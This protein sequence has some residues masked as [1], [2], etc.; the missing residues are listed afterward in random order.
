MGSIEDVDQAGWDKVI[1]T[2]LSGVY[3]VTKA[4][5]DSL[6]EKG[7]NVVMT[8]SVSGIGGD[9]SMF[10][11]NAAKGGVTNLTRALALDAKNSGV[12]VNAVNPSLTRSELTKDMFED[13]AL[14]GKF[15]ERIPLGRV[16]EPEDIA[17]VI[18]VLASDDARF[19][20]GVSLPVDGGV[21]ASNGQPAQA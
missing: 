1:D 18:A 9:W 2:D 19:V 12:R 8:S 3:F 16:A 17:D 4:A 5:W 13:D 21:S 6:K 15:L 14:I 10:A 20:N 7:G 11:Y